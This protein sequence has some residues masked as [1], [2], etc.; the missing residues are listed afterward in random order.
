MPTAVSTAASAAGAE[1][2]AAPSTITLARS[3]RGVRVRAGRSSRA[4]A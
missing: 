2:S 1:P 4:V 3:R